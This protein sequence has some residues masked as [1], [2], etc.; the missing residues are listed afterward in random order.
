MNKFYF[1]LSFIPLNILA[2]EG[3]LD[4]DFIDTIVEK[5]KKEEKKQFLLPQT[6]NIVLE[7]DQTL[8]ELATKFTPKTVKGYSP[9]I[10]K[11][12]FLGIDFHDLIWKC[13]YLEHKIIKKNVDY[14]YQINVDLIGIYWR[15]GIF[16]GIDGGYSWIKNHTSGLFLNISLGWEYCRKRFCRISLGGAKTGN[17]YPIWWTI[18]PISQTFKIHEINESWIL[19]L[20]IELLFKRLISTDVLNIKTN[21]A[22]RNENFGKIPFFGEH[23]FVN[24][25]NTYFGIRFFIEFQYKTKEKQIIF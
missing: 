20:R 7:P 4:K 9:L 16:C 14:F 8:K 19:I 13:W 25:K 17:K 11:V 23:S 22:N 3:L 12:Q 10:Q 18:T 15:N 1:L 24:T 5:N 6:E 21:F 2:D